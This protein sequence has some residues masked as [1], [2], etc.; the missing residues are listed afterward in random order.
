MIKH[1]Y[2]A[3]QIT[4]NYTQVPS[5]NRNQEEKERKGFHFKFKWFKV[6]WRC[7]NY[8]WV[9]DD[10]CRKCV[11]NHEFQGFRPNML[12]SHMTFFAC[13]FWK[14]ALHTFCL[15]PHPN[16]PVV[17]WRLPPS[18]SLFGPLQKLVHQLSCH[19]T[20]TKKADP[21]T[22]FSVHSYVYDGP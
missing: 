10:E 22:H 8:L 3:N 19:N 18:S 11:V 4:F 6:N 2:T 15:P 21:P 16:F 12:W 5:L 7:C 13:Q 14:I 9:I 20:A 17:S 1:C